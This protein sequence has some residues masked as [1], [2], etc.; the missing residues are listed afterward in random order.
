MMHDCLGQ[1][2][3]EP[4]IV[5]ALS[6][7]VVDLEQRFGFGTADRLMLDR[8]RGQDAGAPGGVIGVQRAGKMNATLGGRTFAGNHA[9][10]HDREGKCCGVAAGWFESANTFGGHC[11]RGSHCILFCFFSEPQQS[12]PGMNEWLTIRSLGLV[13]CKQLLIGRCDVGHG[14]LGIRYMTPLRCSA[15]AA[16]SG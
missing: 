8:S 5:A 6:G 11:G 13:F 10:A 2:I 1:Q 15:Q 4:S 3:V 14:S 12:M 16:T 9:I 7:G